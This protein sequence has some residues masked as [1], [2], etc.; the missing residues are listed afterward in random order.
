[1]KTIVQYLRDYFQRE[2]NPRYFCLVGLLLVLSFVVN[3]GYGL[4]SR[5]LPR[6]PLQQ[7]IFY[8]VFF[9]IPYLTTIVLSIVTA[10]RK[11]LL[12]NKGF[13]FLTLGFFALL[14]IYITAH[15]VPGYLYAASPPLFSFAPLNFQPYAVRCAS[16]FLHGFLVFHLG[17][18]PR[19]RPATL[20]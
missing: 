9:F 19:G 15:N 12:R 2:W 18:V 4:E 13:I 5:F 8:F 17:K 1:M 10:G 16:N 20:L 14:S 3:Y 7:C 6:D 11:E